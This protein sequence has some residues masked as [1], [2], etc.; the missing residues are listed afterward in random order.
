MPEEAQAVARSVVKAALAS[1]LAAGL[2]SAATLVWRS[3][4]ENGRPLAA[5][6]APSH[7]LWG[8]RALRRDG[9]SLRYTAFGWAIHQLASHFWAVIYEA[10]QRRDPPT[11]AMAL[12]DAAAL[13][14]VAAVV[15][16]A[17]VPHRLTPGF[18]HRLSPRG[19][20]YV[21]GSFALG[22]ALVGVWRAA[23]RR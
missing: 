13:T 11:P 2:L 17:V 22:L 16:L 20:G 5:I 19:L 7:W 18:E 15:D 9:A 8:D 4:A 6:N 10:L 3:H 21:Y 14:A 23:H 1:G 12:A